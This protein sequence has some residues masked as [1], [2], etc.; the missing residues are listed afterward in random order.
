MT[1]F[2]EHDHPR[3]P[4]GTGDKAGKFRDKKPGGDWADRV[5]GGMPAPGGGSV[6]TGKVVECPVCG[7]VVKVVGNGKRSTHNKSK[8]KRCDGSGQ[9]AT[10]EATTL[11]AVRTKQPP[12]SKKIVAPPGPVLPPVLN[13]GDGV[14][15]SSPAYARLEAWHR[16]MRQPGVATGYDTVRVKALEGLR[17]RLTMMRSYEFAGGLF[18]SHRVDE[19]M[20][21]AGL[22]PLSRSDR[23]RF[24]Y[25]GREVKYD[26]G[27]IEGRRA[28]LAELQAEI[29]RVEAGGPSRRLGSDVLDLPDQTAPRPSPAIEFDPARPLAIY[30]DMLHADRSWLSYVALDSLEQR[31]PPAYHQAMA[32]YLA[33]HDGGIWLGAAKLPDQDDLGRLRG[34]K[35][36]GWHK[37][38]TW[39]E[40]DGVVSGGKTMAVSYTFNTR[41][42]AVRQRQIRRLLGLPDGLYDSSATMHEFGHLADHALGQKGKFSFQEPASR[43]RL[44]RL[45]HGKVKKNAGRGLNPYF[46]QGGDAGPEEFWADAFGVYHSHDPD[47]LDDFDYSFAGI[48]GYTKRTKA[49]AHTYD[50]PWDVAHEIEKYF[51]RH[52]KDV[53]AGRRRPMRRRR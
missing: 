46:R 20:R 24:D 22:D 38:A 2:V 43:Q 14:W 6:A 18:N 31:V 21:D 40:V 30:G 26:E 25:Y 41:S 28:H 42:T 33:D 53:E 3:W 32:S 50:V 29:D 13:L 49:I 11:R 48:Y 17:R 35:P 36:R 19:D 7:R 1:R 4:K 8:G 47:P 23:Q 15:N 34:E 9:P 51:Q 45:V 39:D 27:G 12:R 37:G 5:G 10:G 52:L 16:D 44:W